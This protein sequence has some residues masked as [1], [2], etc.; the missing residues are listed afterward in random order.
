[1]DY[2]DGNSPEAEGFN[3]ILAGLKGDPGKIGKVL[4]N[5]KPTVDD[6]GVM[7]VFGYVCGIVFS[8]LASMPAWQRERILAGLRTSAVK[9]ATELGGYL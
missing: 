5:C 2:V 8:I 6:N 7:E 1:M 4:N 3:L 9:A